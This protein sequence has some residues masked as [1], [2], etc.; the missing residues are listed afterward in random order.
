VGESHGIEA[1]L[2]WMRALRCAGIASH[3]DR[4][5]PTSAPLYEEAVALSGQLSDPIE[6][7]SSL[8]ALAISLRDLGQLEAARL[9]LAESR[10]LWKT[11]GNRW[12]SCLVTAEIGHVAIRQGEYETARQAFHESLAHAHSLAEG[13]Y[14]IYALHNLLVLALVEQEKAAAWQHYEEIIARYNRL[15]N[16]APQMHALASVTFSAFALGNVVPWSAYFVGDYVT[17]QRLFEQHLA[18]SRARGDELLTAW[19][20]NH[21]GDV[22]RSS[23]ES[24]RARTLYQQSLAIF[25]QLENWGGAALP[26]HN[27]GYIHL[28]AGALDRARDHF[29]AALRRTHEIGL[30]W[31]AADCL[32]GFAA[33]AHAEGKH[34]RAARLLG[35]AH[36]IQAAVDVSGAYGSPAIRQEAETIFT[37]VRTTLGEP[38]WQLHHTA[39]ATFT[40]AGAVQYALESQGGHPSFRANAPGAGE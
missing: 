23:G 25:E 34:E 27:L 7:A 1:S 30:A 14:S 20:L 9:R 8:L 4:N 32:I 6:Q 33:L 17:A 12:G 28:H 2:G 39:G 40:Q 3:L 11:T 15:P 36:A 21:L 37:A 35:A 26:L 16:K 22:M 24:N 18:E 10:Q 19:L 31:N 5:L 29:A 38:A 13:W